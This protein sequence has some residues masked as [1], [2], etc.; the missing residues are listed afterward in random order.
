MNA[1]K[2]IGLLTLIASPFVSANNAI[3]F[4]GENGSVPNAP[5]TFPTSSKTPISF[6][7]GYT[8]KDGIFRSRVNTCIVQVDNPEY[9]VKLIWE[10]KTP[11]LLILANTHE[12]PLRCAFTDDMELDLTQFLQNIPSHIFEHLEVANRVNLGR[13]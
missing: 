4:P 9:E 11:Q 3:V 7:N 2:L 6:Y 8:I 13:S 10:G 1:I 5:I 12:F